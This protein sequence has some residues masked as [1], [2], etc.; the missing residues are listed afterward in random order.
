MAEGKLTGVGLYHFASFVKR[1]WR[2]NGWMWGR[3]DG[4]DGL[5]LAPLHPDRLKRKHPNV[6]DA[7]AAVRPGEAEG[8]PEA[9]DPQAGR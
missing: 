1:S 4:V 3:L 2:A 5:A 9:L 6:A 8:S 7:C